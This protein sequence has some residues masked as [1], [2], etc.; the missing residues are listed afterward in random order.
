MSLFAVTMY[1]PVLFDPDLPSLTWAAS[2]LVS[3]SRPCHEA[4]VPVRVPFST[5]VSPDRS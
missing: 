5:G 1:W 2:S 3:G 4:M